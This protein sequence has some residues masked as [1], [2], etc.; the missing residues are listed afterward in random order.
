MTKFRVLAIDDDEDI[1]KLIKFLMQSEGYEVVTASDGETALKLC[2][3]ESFDVILCDVRLPKMTGFEFLEEIKKM[4]ITTPVIMIT[5]Y[6][7]IDSAVEAMK[8]G[9]Y[10]Y[11]PKPFRADELKLVVKRALQ[12]HMLAEENKRLRRELG[13]RFG[14]EAIIGKSKAMQEVFALVE[15]ATQSDI[16]VLLR[17]ESG[18]GKELVARA[19][20]YSGKRQSGPFVVV[21]CSAIPA[22]LLESELFGHEKGAFTGATSKRQG[23]FELADGGTLFLDE[24]GDMS[25]DLQSKLLRVLEHQEFERVGGS[26]IIRVNVRII[27]ATNKNLEEEMAKGNFREDLYFRLNVFPIFLPPLRERKEDIPLLVEH[28]VAKYGAMGVLQDYDWPGNVRELE[29]VIERAV[30]ITEDDAIDVDDLPPTLGGAKITGM[31]STSIVL[32]VSLPEL[33]EEMEKR[34]ILEALKETNW[35]Q[36]R[37][38]K[39]LGLTERMLGY[40]VK[41]Y[42]LKRN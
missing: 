4:N 13:E 39:L 38:A 23:K 18:T 34:F 30:V 25:Y 22:S 17:G 8:L 24:I 3:E 12:Q 31:A 1:L 37:A 33:V 9:A 5:A 10:H 26:E 35:V 11:V 6:A 40:K 42:G 7:S 15:K 21:N 32:P 20:H 29:N 14:M 41:K 16:T 28:F 2:G 27:S 19:I 36:A